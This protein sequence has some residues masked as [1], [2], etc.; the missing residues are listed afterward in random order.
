[1][2]LIRKKQNGYTLVELLI[3]IVMLI[4]VVGVIGLVVVGIHFLAKIW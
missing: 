4:G 1:M 2:K 3:T